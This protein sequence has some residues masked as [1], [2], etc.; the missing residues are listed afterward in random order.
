MRK[1]SLFIAMSRYIADSKGSVDW[2][3]GQGCGDEDIDSYSEF[4]KTFYF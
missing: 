2:L 4:A 1:A 3:H